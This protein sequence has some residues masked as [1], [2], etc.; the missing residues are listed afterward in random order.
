MKK[1]TL[2]F[3]SL[4]CACGALASSGKKVDKSTLAITKVSATKAI[5]NAMKSNGST[6]TFNRV[7]EAIDVN[8]L[9][10]FN[11]TRKFKIVSRSDLDA[12]MKEQSLADSGLVS[13]SDSNAA[14][15][16]QLLGAKY[17]VTV[18]VDDFQ[19]FIDRASFATL[20]KSDE[21][22]TIRIGAIAKIIDSSTSSI[23]ETVNVIVKKRS[24]VSKSNIAQ[25]SG[26]SQSDDSI[27]LLT[28]DISSQIANRV[29]DIIFPPKVIGKTGKI[30]TFNRGDGTGVRVGD[31]YSIF[32]LG[33]E[34]VDPDTGEKLGAEEVDV[35]KMRVISITPKFSKGTLLEDNGVDKGQV[36]RLAKKA[37]VQELTTEDNEI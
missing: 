1:I 4:V 37:P 19:D 13:I 25:H 11:D 2:L 17:I 21:N 23:L 7:V 18:S 5:E 22:R 24:Y 14:K 34:M 27:A 15:M 16:G 8:L 20:A 10:A 29:A 31:E 35:G 28:R 36:L 3:L 33:E 32:A 12:V 30:V 6:A 26:G 9:S